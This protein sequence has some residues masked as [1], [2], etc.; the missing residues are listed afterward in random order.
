MGFTYV[1]LELTKG[2]IAG[3]VGEN[4][5]GKSTTL[6]FEENMG[7]VEWMTKVYE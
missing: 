6:K 1:D 4:G 3:L 5:S 2:K 7:I